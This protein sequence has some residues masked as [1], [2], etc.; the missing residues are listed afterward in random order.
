MFAHTDN[1]THAKGFTLVPNDSLRE[2]WKSC[3][4]LLVG[5]RLAGPRDIIASADFAKAF[6]HALDSD[7]TIV[8]V[9]ALHHLKQGTRCL[10]FEQ[11]VLTG[12]CE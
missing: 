12:L 8:V 9:A 5:A 3:G 4:A 2:I 10:G 7:T 6:W 11:L 1:V